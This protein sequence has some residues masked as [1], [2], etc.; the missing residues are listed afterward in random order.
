MSQTVSRTR[1]VENL[2][3]WM[4]ARQT[5]QKKLALDAGL[6]E[7]AVRDIIA[8]KSP[9]PGILRMCKIARAWGCSLNDL[10]SD[11]PFP[12]EK[13]KGILDGLTPENAQRL[14]DIAVSFRAEQ[15]LARLKRDLNSEHI[16]G[17]PSE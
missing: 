2:I 8:G 13:A 5:S 12:E 3:L 11:R 7:T 1:L 4:E 9:D 17:V 6:A 16:S 14:L 15:E 10:V